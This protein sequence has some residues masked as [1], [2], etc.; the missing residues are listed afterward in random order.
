MG[1]A[2]PTFRTPGISIFDI[3]RIGIG[4]H[5]VQWSDIDGKLYWGAQRTD[6]G[7]KQIWGIVSS[8]VTGMPLYRQI[9]GYGHD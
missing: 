4:I 7:Y 1:R 8:P 6:R 2:P 5:T 9:R 3:A